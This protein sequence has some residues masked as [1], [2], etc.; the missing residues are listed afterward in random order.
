MRA[1]GARGLRPAPGGR[2]V[3]WR[4]P[5]SNGVA[6]SGMRSRVSY[7]FDGPFAGPRVRAQPPQHPPV[8][9]DR[10]VPL[11]GLD[12][13]DPASEARVTHYPAERLRPDLT[14]ADPLVPVQPRPRGPLGV[15][16]VQALE[17]PQ[18]H[19]AVELAP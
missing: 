2:G 7:G 3:A 15:V 16:E 6:W 11:R 4:A 1:P 19:R 14:F 8:V 5:G 13:L 9:R 17:K 18:A 12:D 10:G